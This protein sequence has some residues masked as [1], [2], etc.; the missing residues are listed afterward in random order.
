MTLPKVP[1][2]T[3][4]HLSKLSML[5]SGFARGFASNRS[6]KASRSDSKSRECVVPM[7]T[8]VANRGR[9]KR[10]ATEMVATV[11]DTMVVTAATVVVT[12]AGGAVSELPMAGG[13]KRR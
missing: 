9:K 12:A 1:V 11:M 4:A 2:P 13:A 6:L 10:V 5:M 8:K 3:V 7:A